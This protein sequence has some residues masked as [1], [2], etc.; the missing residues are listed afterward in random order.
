VSE[1]IEVTLELRRR[2]PLELDGRA[3]PISREEF[4]SRYGADPAD[5][6]PIEAFAQ[7]YDLTIVGVDFARRAVVLSG[8]IAAI[9]RHSESS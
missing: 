5:L 9:T 6:P 4:A 1:V 7:A 8:P 3:T 2:R